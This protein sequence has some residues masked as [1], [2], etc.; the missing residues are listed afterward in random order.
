MGLKNSFLKK[1]DKG[2]ICDV[3]E[4]GIII[5]KDYFEL[6]IAEMIGEKLQT[7]GIFYFYVKK[8]NSSPPKKY[9]LNIPSPIKIQFTKVIDSK[10]EDKDSKIFI[11]TEGD[12]FMESETIVKNPN[13]V[14][15]FATLFHSGNFPKTTYEAIYTQYMQVQFDNKT[16][17]GV[18]SSTIEGIISEICRWNKDTS[19]PFR[20]GL[21]KNAKPNDFK[22]IG[23]R[24][25]PRQ[26]S[27][28]SGITFE[29]IN[30]SI[31]SGIARTRTGKE[32]KITSIEKI[33]KM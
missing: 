7:L 1:V 13:N 29:D 17:L 24:N 8:T 15:K 5:P 3:F 12:T 10:T 4:M 16:L 31:A 6:G 18:P 27:T 25:L 22:M 33:V 21:A 28:F 11:M 26:L 23:I 32:E 30:Q 2:I 9:L 14:Y 20:L 19:K